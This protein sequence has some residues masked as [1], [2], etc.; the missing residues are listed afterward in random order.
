MADQVDPD[1]NGNPSCSTTRE[2]SQFREKRSAY[3]LDVKIKLAKRA[4]EL[5]KLWHAEKAANP[6]IRDR[7]RQG[8]MRRKEP[9][10]GYI[11][12]TI[13]ENIPSLR[14]KTGK[15]SFYYYY[16]LIFIQLVC[17]F[18]IIIANIVSFRRDLIIMIIVIIMI[19]IINSSIETCRNL[20]HSSWV[21]FGPWDRGPFH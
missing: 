1:D 12:R 10:W 13:D 9:K 21:L 6:L 17:F 2:L 14:G 8:M 19:M 16:L 18:I 15:V 3:S 5:E 4:I 20:N 7:K 11:N